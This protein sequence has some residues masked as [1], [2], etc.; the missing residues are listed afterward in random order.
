MSN[1]FSETT[2]IKPTIKHDHGF[3]D[4]GKGGIDF[5][6]KRT[7]TAEDL[8]EYAKWIAKL[9]AA[10]T[11]RWDLED[12]TSAYRHFLFGMGT[13]K[14]FDYNEYIDEDE[15]GKAAVKHLLDQLKK[16]AMEITAAR[17]TK[18]PAQTQQ[19]IQ[20]DLC[21]RVIGAGGKK[22]LF[23]PYPKTEN[24]QKAIGAHFLYGKA[25]VKASVPAKSEI[26]AFTIH[27]TMF[28]EDMYNFNPKNQDIKT[29]IPDEANGRFELTGLAQEFLHTSIFSRDYTFE[30]KYNDLHTPSFAQLKNE[31]IESPRNP[32]P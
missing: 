29:K 5:S 24:W 21:S 6:K 30:V 12:A 14:I 4:D 23:F 8:W 7:P 25:S 3:L 17:I 18:P 13:N 20:S 11:I 10:E 26:V 16:I 2:F 1:I 22:D 28:A 27:L 31:R 15:S 32:T 9:E 19:S